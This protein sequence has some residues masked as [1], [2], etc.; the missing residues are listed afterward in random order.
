MWSIS[1]VLGVPGGHHA[2]SCL[3]LVWL[4]CFGGIFCTGRD[5]GAVDSSSDCIGT[6]PVI[7]RKH[8]LGFCSCLLSSHRRKLPGMTLQ[9]EHVP[10]P[11]TVVMRCFPAHTLT[12]VIYT[13]TKTSPTLALGENQFCFSLEFS[14]WTNGLHFP[15]FLERNCFASVWFGVCWFVY[16]SF[17][18]CLV[19]IPCN[20]CRTNWNFPS[21]S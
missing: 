19:M 1:C 5:Q 17:Y 11:S 6:V 20:I 10:F 13:E 8:H 21:F 3:S 15:Q 18:F 7:P 16:V 14:D 9:F 12:A 2:P 4:S